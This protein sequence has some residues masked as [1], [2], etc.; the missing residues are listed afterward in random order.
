MYCGV[1]SDLIQ[2]VFQHKNK[3][4]PSFTEKYGVDK[5]VSFEA[6]DSIEGAIVREKQIKK[7]KRE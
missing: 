1:T 4:V 5:L 6:C 7:W 3:F 2:R